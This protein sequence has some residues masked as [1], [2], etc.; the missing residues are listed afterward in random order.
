ELDDDFASTRSS[1][2]PRATPCVAATVPSAPTANKRQRVELRS[3]IVVMIIL[4]SLRA[5]LPGGA[6]HDAILRQLP[7]EKNTRSPDRA[8]PCHPD[9]DPPVSHRWTRYQQHLPGFA[10]PYLPDQGAAD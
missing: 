6:P 7:L 9:S 4:R 2:S 8:A 1:S 5:A 3:R 10:C